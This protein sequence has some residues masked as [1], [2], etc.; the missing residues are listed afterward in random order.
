MRARMD[1]PSFSLICASIA[2]EEFADD[3]TEMVV[4]TVEIGIC[5][6]IVPDHAMT[7]ADAGVNV[8]ALLTEFLLKSLHKLV[9]L[10]GRYLVGAVVEHYSVIVVILVLRNGDHVHSEG[11]VALLHCKTDGHRFKGGTSL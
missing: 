2:G 9:S 1:S 11:N 3:L 6:G 5:G 4:G 10:L 8:S 7:V